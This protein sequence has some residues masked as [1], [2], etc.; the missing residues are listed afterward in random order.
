MP[1]GMCVE[2]AGLYPGAI[3]E[4]FQV[5][6]MLQLLQGNKDWMKAMPLHLPPTCHDELALV[7]YLVAS[8]P[9]ALAWRYACNEVWVRVEESVKK[10]LLQL[11]VSK[12]GRV[13]TLRVSLT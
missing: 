11:C 12:L 13:S 7:L 10:S 1:G 6:S 5:K 4:F 3:C 9:V 8:V 2:E